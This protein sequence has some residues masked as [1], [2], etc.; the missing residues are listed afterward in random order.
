MLDNLPEVGVEGFDKV[1]NEGE[2]SHHVVI[3]RDSEH[4]EK[5]G[6]LSKYYPHFF[7]SIHRQKVGALKIN[8]SI[9]TTLIES[10]EMTKPAIRAKNIK[11]IEFDA[12]SVVTKYQP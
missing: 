4:E 2:V 7:I 6:I 11:S 3:W 12:I 1:V 10:S 9:N 8:C 5:R